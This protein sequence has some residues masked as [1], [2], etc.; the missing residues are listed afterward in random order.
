MVVQIGQGAKGP[1]QMTARS[2][3]PGIFSGI[4][5]L[6]G[7]GTVP[8]LE[9]T[10]TQGLAIPKTV[11]DTRWGLP[12]PAHAQDPGQQRTSIFRWLSVPTAL[13][14]RVLE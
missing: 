4:F 9:S 12:S 14:K 6:D 10:G 2:A 11:L 3:A 8:M 5:S 13:G 7:S 1:F